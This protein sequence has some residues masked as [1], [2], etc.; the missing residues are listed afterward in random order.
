MRKHS[1]ELTKTPSSPSLSSPS[2]AW[3]GFLAWV[4]K[5]ALACGLVGALMGVAEG[6]V[7]GA[8][9]GHNGPQDS[10]TLSLASDRGLLFGLMGFA[11]GA[12]SG[13]V[14]KVLQA[15]KKEQPQ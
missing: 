15:W 11:L 7:L 5:R 8:I 13:T 9:I 10:S 3:R 6:V 2:P 4:I 14:T 1:M 12:V